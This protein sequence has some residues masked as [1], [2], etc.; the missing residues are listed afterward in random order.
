ML[1]LI[2]RRKDLRGNDILKRP[3]DLLL[4]FGEPIKLQGNF[5]A[6]F[7]MLNLTF[8]EP[9]KL[10]KDSASGKQEDLACGETETVR[11]PKI[12]LCYNS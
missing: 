10:I 5:Y 7:D 11:T 4:A 2:S 12:K 6:V 8:G 1:T 3:I 9:N